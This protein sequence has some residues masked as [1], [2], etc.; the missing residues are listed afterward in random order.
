[1]N[2]CRRIRG[3]LNVAPIAVALLALGSAA[4][5]A[6]ADDAPTASSAKGSLVITTRG[7]PR[8][9]RASVAVSGSHYHVGIATGTAT[10]QGLRPGRYAIVVKPVLISRPHGRIARGAKAYPARRRIRVTVS[11]GKRARVSAVYS[12]I[13]N[14]SVRALPNH[15]VGVEGDPQNPTQLRFAAKTRA[16]KPG[17]IL[18]SAATPM[19]PYGLLSKVT[20]AKRQSGEVAVSVEPAPIAEAAPSLTYDGALE[21]TPIPGAPGQL[22]DDADPEVASARVHAA[23]ACSGSGKVLKFGAHLD[24]VEL[25]QASLGAFPPQMRLTLA[26]RTTESLGLTATAGLSCN[27]SL[28]NIGPYQAAIP[29]GPVVIPVY[30]TMP[31]TAGIDISGKM[32]AGAVNVASTTVA[33]VAAGS[34]NQ[35]SLTQQ[36]TNVWMSGNPGI[37]GTAKL[38]AG[39][40]MQAGIGVAKGANVHLEADFGASFSWTSGQ[41]CSLALNLGRLTAGVSVFG[42]NLNAPVFRGYDVPIWSG[43]DPSRTA[44]PPG[45]NTPPP[46]P[47]TTPVSG[48]PPSGGGSPPPPPPQ[49]P[50]PA[51][52]TW[53]ETVGGPT[54]TW[55]NWTNAGGY[56]GPTIA[57]GQTVQIAC[58]LP[59]F[60]VAD[61]NTWWYRI[62]Q[63]P[64]NSNYYA[65]ADAFYNN[66]QTSGSLRG[67]P[68]V[69]PNV[70]DC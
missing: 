38:R 29:L 27:F 20:S 3:C 22:G 45:A 55:T 57:T 62:A 50:P 28:G 56:E 33:S 18:S 37:S 5:A 8:G 39:I 17:T 47:T 65:S 16:P 40:G 68:W 48:G 15:A 10:L 41:K 31:V 42:R 70:R 59:G 14:P 9:Q 4:P 43:C 35:V 6:V 54:H 49:Q 7:L 30:A 34:Q 61:G 19:L 25:R 44:E 67:T 2:A 36:G 69:D 64:W 60:R 32:T 51:A 63:S 66:G 53:A 11:A 26:V 52:P 23:D 1:M 12:G 21:M 46:A 13:L 24:K 58:K